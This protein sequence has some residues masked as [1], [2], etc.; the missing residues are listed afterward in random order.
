[1]YESPSNHTILNIAKASQI[2]ASTIKRR[3][4]AEG[5]ERPE[6]VTNTVVSLG[7]GA[8]TV[9]S[10][11]AQKV[12]GITFKP[13][14]GSTPVPYWKVPAGCCRF[15]LGDIPGAMHEALTCALPVAFDG[16]PYCE[17]HPKPEDAELAAYRQRKPA[18]PNELIRSLR[19]YTG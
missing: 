15:I 3:I 8:T 13:V 6:G 1:M 14:P 12:K 19:R 7:N 2:P 9:M 5:W 18:S 4:A 16:H 10:K 11:P 17:H